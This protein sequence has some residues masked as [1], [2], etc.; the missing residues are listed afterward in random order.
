MEYVLEVKK[1]TVSYP[2]G[3]GKTKVALDNLNLEVEKGE[4]IGL[5]GPNGA[6]KTTMIK[7]VLGLLYPHATVL[8]SPAV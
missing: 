2:A 8:F 7:A 6:G 5:L 1:L 3:W 4:I